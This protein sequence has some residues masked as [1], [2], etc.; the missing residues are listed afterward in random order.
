MNMKNDHFTI[1]II[2]INQSTPL[3]IREQL[4]YHSTELKPVITSLYN[5]PVLLEKLFLCT[6]NRNLLIFV[7]RANDLDR[8]K[9]QSIALFD[10]LAKMHI[11]RRYIRF[12]TE[13]NAL[14]KLIRLAIG[15]ESAIFGEDQ[16]LG[17]IKLFYRIFL[18]HKLTGV[19]LNKIIQRLQF[20]A[21]K[22]KHE[23]PISKGRI[24]LPGLVIE[25]VEEFIRKTDKNHS[26]VLI[27]GWGEITYTIF[28]ILSVM[29]GVEKISIANRTL[30]KINISC[31]KFSI[32]KIVE[33]AKNFDIIISMT[34]RLGYVINSKCFSGDIINDTLLIDLGVPRNIDPCLSKSS[35]IK[36]VNIDMLN[37]KAMK[38]LKNRKQQRSRVQIYISEFQNK[39]IEFIEHY[40]RQQDVGQVIERIKS[41][42]VCDWEPLLKTM[43][44]KKKKQIINSFCKKMYRALVA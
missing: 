12:C 29:R 32:D 17:Q 3:E 31:E 40:Q 39:M 16:I 26:R 27:V 42:I 5:K 18:S 2:E 41:A 36:I 44:S 23:I 37:S 19:I 6:C 38:N 34:S 8:A 30:D 35:F 4:N 43:D 14:A 24:S 7:C 9:R 15:M 22:I 28:K 10:Q 13:R 20:V 25:E 33:I 11:P 21:K 1:G